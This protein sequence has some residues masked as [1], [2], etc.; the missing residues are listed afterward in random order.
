MRVAAGSPTPGPSGVSERP[1]TAIEQWHGLSED[2]F[3]SDITVNS[4][5]EG[6]ESESEAY[7]A[8]K[9]LAYGV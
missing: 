2:E 8:K 9:Q 7:D 4:E 3:I 1:A 5:S 6:G